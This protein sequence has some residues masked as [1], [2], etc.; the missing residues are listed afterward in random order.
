[1]AIGIAVA[2]AGA[3][4]RFTELIKR[5]A[6]R[7]I[8]V[9]WCTA[10]ICFSSFWVGM[11]LY[12]GHRYLTALRDGK[13]SVVAGIVHVIHQ[14]PYGG[15]D[16]GDHIMIG[17]QDFQYSDYS[18]SLSYAQTISHGGALKEGVRARLF[19]LGGKILEVQVLP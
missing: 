17:G 7:P 18:A 2:Y 4:G 19:C 3:T 15:H 8:F 6:D 10:W 5:K 9:V 11:N 12:K 16:A 1:L 14:Q 13:C